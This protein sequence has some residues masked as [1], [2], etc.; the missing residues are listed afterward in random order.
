V[1]DVRRQLGATRTGEVI[2][3]SATLAMLVRTEPCRIPWVKTMPIPIPDAGAIAVALGIAH[4]SKDAVTDVVKRLLGPTADRAGQTASDYFFGKRVEQGTSILVDG[5]QL[6][7]DAGL[8]VQPVHR[9]IL[10]PILEYGSWEEE[11]ELRGLW[12]ALL[13]N[14]ASPG[15]ANKI[16]PAFPEILRQLTPVQAS[17]LQWMYEKKVEPDVPDWFPMWPDVARADIEFR[18]ALSH[19][20]YAL[21]VTDLER[22]NLIEPRRDIPAGASGTTI[23]MEKLLGLVVG[24]WNS[25]V[26]YESIGFTTLGLRFIQACTPPQSSE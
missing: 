12:A 20:D 4:A 8:E 18:F 17:I 9:R 19:E 15:P 13:A 14:A 10:I 22:L 2:R 11:P 7:Q 26:K 25:R 6:A 1:A 3:A 21:L 16:L 23:P 24:R 5:V